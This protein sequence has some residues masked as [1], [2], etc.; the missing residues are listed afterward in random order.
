MRAMVLWSGGVESTSL[1]KWVLTNTDW[2]VHA[3]HVRMNNSEGRESMEDRALHDL[4]PRLSTL[5]KFAGVSY[6]DVSVCRG[7]VVPPDYWLLYPIGAAVAQAKNCDILLRGWC[8]EDDWLRHVDPAGRHTRLELTHGRGQ[9]GR[10]NMQLDALRPFA[11][12]GVDVHTFC[13]WL[14]P[15]T[16]AKAQHVANLGDWARMT[17]S[18]RRPKANRPCGECFSC[19]AREA[20][21]RS[22]SAIA[23][24]QA[25]LHNAN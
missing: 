2:Q 7:H 6:S 18:C 1:L 16:W 10:W 19:H 17:W 14:E 11:P 21:M 3:H 12:A 23:E 4:L 15:H 9:A 24:V 25:E 13:P 5:R 20:A 8:S 22:A